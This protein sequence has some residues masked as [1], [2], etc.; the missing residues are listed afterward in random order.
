MTLT[1][2]DGGQLLPLISK[3]LLMRP[4]SF[5]GS[6]LCGFRVSGNTE[7]VMALGRARRL[8]IMLTDAELEA[9][10]NWRF[11]RRMPSVASAVRELLKRGLAAE[12]FVIA[13]KDVKSKDFGILTKSKRK[14]GRRN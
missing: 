2:L 12:G 1:P 6:R 5:S 13:D 14:G 10:G 7:T 4:S 3:K 8:Q 9:I 11:A